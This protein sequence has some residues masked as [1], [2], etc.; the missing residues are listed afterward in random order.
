MV[1]L[2][3]RCN[4]IL[5]GF[6]DTNHPGVKGWFHKGSFGPDAMNI[7]DDMNTGIG[8]YIQAIEP[9]R[10]VVV[11]QKTGTLLGMFMF[12]PRRQLKSVYVKGVGEIPMPRASHGPI[13][14]L[15]G[16][17]FKIESRKIRQIEG[18]SVALP[19][20]AGEGWPSSDSVNGGG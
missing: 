10:T 12:N 15:M 5:D 6:Q 19:Y 1:P 2:E 8:S 7:R 17:F 4:R 9:R 3:L 16:E 13:S 14:V 20:A 11:D 18:F